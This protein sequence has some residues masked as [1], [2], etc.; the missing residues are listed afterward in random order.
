MVCQHVFSLANHFL[1]LALSSSFLR[2]SLYKKGTLRD[3]SLLFTN[4]SAAASITKKAHKDPEYKNILITDQDH[5]QPGI[6][7]QKGY[8]RDV[9]SWPAGLISMEPKAKVSSSS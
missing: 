2:L 4:R 1:R 8:S 7:Y 5:I 3:S 6:N 9:P